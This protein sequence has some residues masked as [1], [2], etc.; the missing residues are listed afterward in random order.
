MSFF[1]LLTFS[2]IIS[3]VVQR[4]SNV[5]IRYVYFELVY[6]TYSTCNMKGKKYK[7]EKKKKKM[8]KYINQSIPNRYGHIHRSESICDVCVTTDVMT[9]SSQAR[10]NTSHQ[11]WVIY[12]GMVMVPDVSNWS[13]LPWCR[14]NAMHAMQCNQCIER[15]QSIA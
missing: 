5:N 14:C 2:H 15:L 3:C 12:V 6:T 10:N 1:Q 11:S 4:C 7:R 13:Q 8:K 9:P